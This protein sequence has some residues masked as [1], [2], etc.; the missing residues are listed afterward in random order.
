MNDVVEVPG[1]ANPLTAQNLFNS[2]A[3]AASSVQQQVQIGTQQLQHWEKQVGF[4][5][6]LQ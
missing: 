6:L 2:L 5:P 1:E 3:A 4:Y